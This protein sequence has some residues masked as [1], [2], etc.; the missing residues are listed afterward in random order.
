M[1]AFIDYSARSRS[2]KS[3]SSGAPEGS[4][5]EEAAAPGGSGRLVGN[6]HATGV[7]G[8]TELRPR[9]RHKESAQH[10]TTPD[11]VAEDYAGATGVRAWGPGEVEGTRESESHHVES[12]F[13]G[14]PPI[15]DYPRSQPLERYPS[16][17]SA[18][19][20]NFDD[21][22]DDV[23]ESDE[24]V[25]DEPAFD[26]RLVSSQRSPPCEGEATP[27]REL[28]KQSDKGKRRT[29]VDHDAEEADGRAAVA[30]RDVA[31]A[32]IGNGSQGLRTPAA[33]RLSPPSPAKPPSPNS[34]VGDFIRRPQ[35]TSSGNASRSLGSSGELTPQDRHYISRILVNLQIQRE[36]SAL[37][38]IGTLSKY[39]PPFLP[40][41]YGP[42]SRPDSAG[43]KKSSGFLGFLGGKEKKDPEWEGYNWDEEQVIESPICQ[44]LYWRFVYNLPALRTARPSYWTDQIQPFFDS[45]AERDLS[46]TRERGEITKRRMLATG[47]TRILG[48]Y[49]STC[50]RPLGLSSPARPS[51]AMM[52]QIDLLVP[53][54]M[55]SMW[56]LLH[57][58]QPEV[59]YT[60]W[61]A[62][63]EEQKAQDETIFRIISRVL[64][65]EGQPLYHAFHRWSA[66]QQLSSSFT[67]L[68]PCNSLNLPLLPHASSS[69][70]ASRSVIQRYLRLLVIAL[71]APPESPLDS[72][73][74][75][76]ARNILES[77]LLGPSDE[78]SK[79]DL[80]GWARR[81]EEQEQEDEKR[82]RKWVSSGKR[83]KRLRTTWVRYR[84]ALV[85][86]DEIDKTMEQVRKHS[87]LKALPQSYQ[88]AEE[89]AKIWVAHALHY[90]FIASANGSEVLNIL[91]GFHELI[92]YGPIKL[93]LSLVNPTL[94]IR[95]IV[96]LVLGQP[97][98]QLSLFQRIWSIICHNANKHQRRLIETYRKKIDRAS[99]CDV[100][101]QHVKAPYVERQRTKDISA[102]KN[103]DIVLEIMRER[104]SPSD[105]E[106]VER[107]HAEFLQAEASGATSPTKFDDLKNLLA[108]YYRFRDREQVLAIA[109]EPNTPKLLHASIAIFYD[110]IYKVANAS[111]LSERVGDVQ[112]FLDDLIKVAT[113][114]N[115]GPADFIK[116][117]DRHHEKLY[118][119][120]YELAS[121]GGDLLKPLIE[122]C[123]SG[124]RF[125]S[126]GIPPPPDSSTP[127]PRVGIDIEALLASLPPSASSPPPSASAS[128]PS[129]PTSQRVTKDQVLLEARSFARRTRYRKAYDDLCLR[130]DLLEAEAGQDTPGL[131]AKLDKQRL[132]SE[133]LAQDR[134][135]VAAASS[136][137]P[138]LTKAQAEKK[139]TRTDP[140]GDLE[141]AW[142]A[143][144]ELGGAA[145]KAK[146]T[147]AL[148][149]EDEGEGHGEKQAHGHGHG[150]H[151]GH[152]GHH[153]HHHHGAASSVK[154]GK[155]KLSRKASRP[156]TTGSRAKSPGA[157]SFL[158]VEAADYADS[159]LSEGEEERDDEPRLEIAAP[160]VKATKGLLGTY[161][162]QIKKALSEAK[163]NGV[164]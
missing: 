78:I 153:K 71:S 29:Q 124:L 32:K 24:P 119:F 60:A 22:N 156:S 143:A 34:N 121:N 113:S 137:S 118:Y 111:K 36:F 134:D 141:W 162:E 38:Q 13:N 7:D 158:V 163:E 2:A 54:S 5:G 144:E 91:K 148:P 76:D 116:L 44:Y 37:S 105:V 88:D 133:F 95:A 77:F 64:V 109:L 149:S 18:F 161:L 82:Y 31:A 9:P 145:G 53:G 47:I 20:E 26:A 48:T 117:A 86:T 107:W 140:G 58:E 42:N 84:L 131:L 10:G 96:Q 27:R 142:W 102:A 69:R 94:A 98:G 125:I 97:A 21:D 12:P 65:A 123:K 16:V 139:K 15:V 138:A 135:V 45:F 41:A 112:A 128:P 25:V 100:L 101:Q 28:S 89:W 152:S 63:V 50:V 55:G 66:L 92:P 115:N 33:Y 130:I 49:F 80:E 68:D 87:T 132:W 129:T 43:S 154:S 151:H 8:R 99:V 164:K 85:E 67:S 126:S 73:V 61:V 157:E 3:A 39:G 93:G 30:R 155:G 56:R 6:V 103:E 1:P 19:R 17:Q 81:G 122:W 120:V 108:A 83:V 136:S 72:E 51:L 74:L 147:V 62:V 11:E 90:I 52:R 127:N 110:T 4:G 59:A 104:G 106:L 14:A 57:P 146:V 150:G 35:S 23:P 70:P 160:E 46:S 114:G 75:S 159:L 40:F 79:R